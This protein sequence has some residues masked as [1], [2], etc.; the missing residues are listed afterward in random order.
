MLS[1]E[2]ICGQMLTHSVEFGMI[3]EDY[4]SQVQVP[5]VTR[6]PSLCDE[7]GRRLDYKGIKRW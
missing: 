5:E 7:G 1:T 3:N 4:G 2:S 6:D